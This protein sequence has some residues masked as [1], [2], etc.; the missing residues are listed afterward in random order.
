ME[1][2][3]RDNKAKAFRNSQRPT[4]CKIENSFYG[5]REYRSDGTVRNYRTIWQPRQK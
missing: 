1:N 3:D 5:S 2:N 4:L